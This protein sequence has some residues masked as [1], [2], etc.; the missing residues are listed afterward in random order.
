MSIQS[1]NTFLLSDLTIISAKRRIRPH[2][3]LHG[4]GRETGCIK[5]PMVVAPSLFLHWLAC[6]LILPSARISPS[7]PTSVFLC[8]PNN[9]AFLH[10]LYPPSVHLQ[11]CGPTLPCPYR[12]QYIRRR[13]RC[14]LSTFLASCPRL[15]RGKIRPQA[16]DAT[17][18]RLFYV[19]R[20]LFRQQVINP[21]Q[22]VPRAITYYQ[23]RCLLFDPN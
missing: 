9:L 2:T 14:V 15:S 7:I 19:L 3:K 18:H 4:D 12:F 21:G 22:T 11:F 23:L 13:F 10:F 5:G 20:D 6:G 16:I 17:T 8:N 1:I